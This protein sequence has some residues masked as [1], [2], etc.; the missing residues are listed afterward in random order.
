[1]KGCQWG[2]VTKEPAGG[3]RVLGKE[4]RTWREGRMVD[5]HAVGKSAPEVWGERRKRKEETG[6]RCNGVR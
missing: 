3:E 4:G 1:M 5:G 6:G 2:W